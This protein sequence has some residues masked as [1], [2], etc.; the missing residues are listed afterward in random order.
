[1]AVCLDNL[2]TDCIGY[3]VSK[4]NR[5]RRNEQWGAIEEMK[6]AVL[7]TETSAG[8]YAGA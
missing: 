4:N 3:N 8:L 2:S 7:K 5:E 1:M 6:L